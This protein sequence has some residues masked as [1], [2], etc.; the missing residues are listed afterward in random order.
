MNGKVIPLAGM[1]RK[2]TAILI[3]LCTANM[4][5]RP[6]AA[7]RQNGS[8]VRAASVSA[9]QDDEGEEGDQ[10]HAGDHAEFL[11]GHGENEVGMRVGKDSLVDALARARAPASRRRECSAS[12][13]ST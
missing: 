11:A 10:R 13:V 5:V 1:A 6:A 12:A 4:T 7:S 8:G 2:L 3:Q 9:L